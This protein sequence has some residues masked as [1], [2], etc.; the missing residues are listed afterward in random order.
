MKLRGLQ[1]GMEVLVF[2]DMVVEEDSAMVVV[3]EDGVVQE[4][5][6]V[7]EVM[8]MEEEVYGAVHTPLPEPLLVTPRLVFLRVRKHV[9]KISE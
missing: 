3:V 8:M 9:A 5:T 2:A 6:E 1:I 4:V 7:A